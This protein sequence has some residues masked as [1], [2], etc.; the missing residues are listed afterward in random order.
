M[1]LHIGRKAPFG[2]REV[3]KSMHLGFGVWILRIEPIK[4]KVEKSE[5][6]DPKTF[7]APR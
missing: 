7:R 4:R 2:Y 6:Y 5:L 1:R 3:G